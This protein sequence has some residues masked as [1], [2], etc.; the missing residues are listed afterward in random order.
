MTK[1]ME[2]INEL[3]RQ[4]AYIQFQE[5]LSMADYDKICEL[6]QQIDAIKNPE[7]G[8]AIQLVHAGPQYSK[9]PFYFTGDETLC[10]G[11]KPTWFEDEIEAMFLFGKSSLAENRSDYIIKLI[12][13]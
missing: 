2:K 6:E 8:V 12:T 9:T 11:D 1:N 13:K 3:K 7:K 5:H 4:I 10:C